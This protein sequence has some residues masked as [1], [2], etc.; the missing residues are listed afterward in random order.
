MKV[1]KI[2]DKETYNQLHS[3]LSGFAF[4]RHTETEYYIKSPKTPVLDE[5]LKLGLISVEEETNV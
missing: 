3:M 4:F 1:Y 2:K 5:L